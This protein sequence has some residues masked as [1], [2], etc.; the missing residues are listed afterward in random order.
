MASIVINCDGSSSSFQNNGN[1][2]VTYNTDNGSITLT[3]IAGWRTDQWESYNWSDTTATITIGGVAK[4]VGMSG[5]VHFGSYSNEVAWGLNDTTWTGLSGNQTIVVAPSCSSSTIA[6]YGN[7][8]TSTVEVAPPIVGPTINSAS[9]SGGLGTASYTSSVTAGSSS[10]LTYAWNI[11]GQTASGSSGNI[12]GLNHNKNYNWSLT[13]TDGN[14]KTA[15]TS[16]SFTT[17]H[18]A[19][20]IG[21][22]NISHT[23]SSGT[24]TTDI[25]YTVTYDGA[26]YS[27]HSLVYGT[28][29][30]YGSNAT[31]SSTGTNSSFRITGLEPN[32]T[33]YYKITEVDN[34]IAATTSNTATGS[35]TTP[36][37]SPTNLSISR[38]NS[39][40]NSIS[41]SVSAS[42]DTNAPITNYTL[43]YRKGT[44]GTYT[45]TS[46]GTST[47]KTISNLDVDTNYQFYFTA[48]NAG[49]TT[50]SSTLTCSTILTNP[51]I[52]LTSS[53]ITPTSITVI[54]TGSISPSRTLQYRFSNNNGSTW[55]S[56]QSSNTYTWSNLTPET[57]YNIK[58]M[59]KATHIGTN[60]SDTTATSSTLTVRTLVDQANIRLKK[61]GHWVKGKGYYKK[62]GHWEKI[63]KIYIKKNGHWEEGKN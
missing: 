36:C 23:R 12:T 4:T 27:S 7:K 58:A 63:K 8:F 21:S 34:G 14:S 5:H 22:R 62:N 13:V 9:V 25:S 33:Y 61:S 16:G 51:T 6:Y 17:T 46:L 24:Y 59:V 54:A 19:P 40:T 18:N 44:S 53:D 39:T 38:T 57:N 32:K 52:S 11:G 56:Y 20:V 28:S 3:E 2:R 37:I 60:A 49:G 15:S 10:S 26:S 30:S 43:Y 50:T 42:G 29:T 48:T 1:I 47:T 41:I 35:F 45:S 55:T 31:S